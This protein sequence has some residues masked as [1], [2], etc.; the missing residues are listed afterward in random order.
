MHI[1]YKSIAIIRLGITNTKNKNISPGQD[2]F[3]KMTRAY[4]A[5][6]RGVVIVCDVSR[7]GTVDA[8]KNWK[9]EI[10]HWTNVNGGDRALN[11]PVILFA[12]KADLLTN[13]QE[14]FKTGATMER[15]CREQGK[16]LDIY[17]SYNYTILPLFPW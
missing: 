8:I 13:A 17:H 12:N 16:T 15:I 5:K 14:A 9:R 6:A 4:F 11:I 10:D 1:K 7:E 2:R 3:Q